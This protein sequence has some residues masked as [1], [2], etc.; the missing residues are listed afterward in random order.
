MPEVFSSLK[1]E[2]DVICQEVHKLVHV[3]DGIPREAQRATCTSRTPL[4]H[5]WIVFKIFMFH[6]LLG[7]SMHKNAKCYPTMRKAPC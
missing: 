6:S 1:G 4:A 2:V 7:L 3:L 5:G